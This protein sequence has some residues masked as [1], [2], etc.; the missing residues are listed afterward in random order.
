MR[1]F[2]WWKLFSTCRI[3]PISNWLI[4]FRK[5]FGATGARVA[6]ICNHIFFSCRLNSKVISLRGSHRCEDQSNRRNEE[7]P[8]EVSRLSTTAFGW[9]CEIKQE[10]NFIVDLCWWTH[11]SLM[12]HNAYMKNTLRYQNP[13]VNAWLQSYISVVIWS[14]EIKKCT[15]ESISRVSNWQTLVKVKVILRGFITSQVT[16]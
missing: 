13:N 3:W 7:V 9:F 10:S 5:R 2:N 1:T 8:K 12:M 15:K 14:N 11:F 6:S 16:I 4:H